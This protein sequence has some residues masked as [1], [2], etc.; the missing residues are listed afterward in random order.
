MTDRT[1]VIDAK[2][3]RSDYEIY[4]VTTLA[5]P[6]L[7]SETE[8]TIL[9]RD[10]NPL[11]VAA[12]PID[13][14]GN[15]TEDD[16]DSFFMIRPNGRVT[17]VHPVF[18]ADSGSHIAVARYGDDRSRI[19]FIIS[20]QVI[21]GGAGGGLDEI[22]VGSALGGTGEESDPLDV[23]ADGID[24]A[25]LADGAVKLEKMAPGTA[26]KGIGYDS[27]GNPA[28]IPA[29]ELEYYDTTEYAL[30]TTVRTLTL[31]HNLGVVPK[32]VQIWLICETANNGWDVDDEVF[33]G[34]VRQ[35]TFFVGTQAPRMLWHTATT[36]SVIVVGAFTGS[37]ADNILMVNKSTGAGV[38]VSQ[39]NW[40]VRIKVI[41]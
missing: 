17:F 38:S 39:T 24:S 19:H 25:R 3:D 15:L 10:I 18:D 4:D 23:V 13:A 31:T 32:Q 16:R 29:G 12:V 35:D 20:E 11:L 37:T 1:I 26:Y 22:F 21:E 2:P 14:D 41:A 30:D 40:K 34:D 7:E 27:S 33:Y 28:E 9:N 36:T 6:D 8:Y 5:D